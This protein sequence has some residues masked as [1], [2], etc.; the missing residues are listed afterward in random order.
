MPKYLWSLPLRISSTRPHG[1][2]TIYPGRP[3]ELFTRFSDNGGMAGSGCVA[4]DING[5]HRPDVVCI[6]AATG[7]LKWYENLGSH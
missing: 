2:K 6:G 4:A 5:D 1:L 7:N 3:T